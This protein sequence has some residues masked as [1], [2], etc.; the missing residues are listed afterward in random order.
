[1]E[2]LELSIDLLTFM[3]YVLFVNVVK[4]KNVE[5]GIYDNLLNWR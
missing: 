3:T 2:C 4:N 1:M 5:S